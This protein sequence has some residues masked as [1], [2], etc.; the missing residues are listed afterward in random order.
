MMILLC[1]VNLIKKS[2]RNAA[3]E[4]HSNHVE[5][6][7]PPT[8]LLYQSFMHITQRI[9]YKIAPSSIDGVMNLMLLWAKL[10]YYPT[11]VKNLIYLSAYK[12]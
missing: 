4:I 5:N 8:S 6:D 2:P 11:F 12:K 3:S 1:S 9:W 7:E 10:E